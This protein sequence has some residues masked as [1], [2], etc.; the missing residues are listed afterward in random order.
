MEKE[1]NELLA[2]MLIYL[3]QNMSEPVGKHEMNYVQRHFEQNVWNAA[4]EIYDSNDL[5]TV[6]DLITDR[7]A[8]LYPDKKERHHL[9]DSLKAF[10]EADSKTS[11]PEMVLFMGLKSI[12]INA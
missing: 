12:I 3:I 10:V 8:Q 9:V 2:F 11:G 1:K 5:G 6:I 7:V 4:L